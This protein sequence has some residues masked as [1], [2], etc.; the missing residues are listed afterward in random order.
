M[1]TDDMFDLFFEH[2]ETL[3]KRTDKKNQLYQEREGFQVVM[4]LEKKAITAQLP[5][6]IIAVPILKLWI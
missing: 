3:R 6:I 4:R 2:V 5:R 1:K